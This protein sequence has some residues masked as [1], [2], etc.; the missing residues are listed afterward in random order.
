MATEF[1]EKQ[2]SLQVSFL[3]MFQ[4]FAVPFAKLSGAK[5][6]N[7]LAISKP[8]ATYCS[9]LRIQV[10]LMKSFADSDQG[11]SLFMASEPDGSRLSL[12]DGKFSFD[13]IKI[14]RQAESLLGHCCQLWTANLVALT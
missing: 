5:H 11:A 9:E 8:L 13:P 2:L 6:A 12:L 4:N 7:N 3:V 10:R 14:V 1:G